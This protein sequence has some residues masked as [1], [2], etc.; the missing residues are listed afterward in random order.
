MYTFE[1]LLANVNIVM[2]FFIVLMSP[3][4][5]ALKK[6]LVTRNVITLSKGL[7][8]NGGAPARLGGLAHLGE[9]SPSLRNIICLYEK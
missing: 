2:L 9:I 7:F 4:I 8:I 6:I 1:V 3:L 5:I